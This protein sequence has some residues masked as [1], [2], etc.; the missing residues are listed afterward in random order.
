MGGQEGCSGVG[1]C[2][3][4]ELPRDSRNTG[5]W[6]A[7]TPH[8]ARPSCIPLHAWFSDVPPNPCPPPAFCRRWECR[9]GFI[10]SAGLLQ[11]PGCLGRLILARAQGRDQNPAQGYG[12]RLQ[13]LF[14]EGSSLSEPGFPLPLGSNPRA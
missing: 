4:R 14:A 7:V 3:D 9:T 2:T 5:D 13:S 11:V 10:P 12:S 6:W 1:W 8:P